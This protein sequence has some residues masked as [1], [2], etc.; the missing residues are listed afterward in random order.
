MNN[1]GRVKDMIPLANPDS[2]KFL[3]QP[4]N[5]RKTNQ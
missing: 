1:F 5:Q 3:T 2:G 4:K